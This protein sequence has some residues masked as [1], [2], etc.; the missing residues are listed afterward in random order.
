M[1]VVLLEVRRSM[2]MVVV[3]DDYK[4]GN[5]D[6]GNGGDGHHKKDHDHNKDGVW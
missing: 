5:E 3:L 4:N 1:L 6:K 2:V